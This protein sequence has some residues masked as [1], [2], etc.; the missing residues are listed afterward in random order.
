MATPTEKSS[1]ATGDSNSATASSRASSTQNW[2]RSPPPRAGR[3]KRLTTIAS[4]PCVAHSTSATRISQVRR[5]RRPGWSVCD[6]PNSY[7]HGHCRNQTNRLSETVCSA[8]ET[9][10]ASN[11][12]PG[13]SVARQTASL[14]PSAV[15]HDC[16]GGP[17]FRF[18]RWFE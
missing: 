12:Q 9:N 16:P 13:G 15:F 14:G 8:T 10:G 18:R 7:L 17:V 3:Q 2:W 6:S 4:A 5:A 11:D 1:A